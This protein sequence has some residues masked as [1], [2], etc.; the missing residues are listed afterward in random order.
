MQTTTRNAI[1]GVDDSI[2]G[3]FSG[4]VRSDT[5]FH[6]NTSSL[7]FLKSGIPPNSAV[8]VLE[9][10]AE[11]LQNPFKIKDSCNLIAIPGTKVSPTKVRVLQRWTGRVEE[12]RERSFVARLFDGQDFTAPVEEAEIDKDEIG[13]SDLLLLVPGA[14]FYWTLGYID[15]SGGQRSRSSDLRFARLSKPDP[16]MIELAKV[17]AQNL[18]DLILSGV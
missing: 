16:E 8:K 17:R 11:D 10:S 12:V 3:F 7:R 1:E 6:D 18:A 15:S 13:P 9:G 2:G 5:P 4:H 14:I